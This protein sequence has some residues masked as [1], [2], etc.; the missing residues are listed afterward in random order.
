MGDG[1]CVAESAEWWTK[2]EKKN[3]QEEQPNEKGEKTNEEIYRK[4]YS[5]ETEA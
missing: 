3:D 4:K 2:K 1:V 5:K